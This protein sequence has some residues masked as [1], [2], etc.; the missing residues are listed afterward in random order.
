MLE[1]EP[2]L[3][4]LTLA[5]AMIGKEAAPSA[6]VTDEQ[7]HSVHVLRER[8]KSLLFEAE[9]LELLVSKA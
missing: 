6:W 3:L 9:I 1:W 4:F 8:H 5:L 7:T 2:P